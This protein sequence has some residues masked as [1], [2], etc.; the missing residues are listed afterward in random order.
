MLHRNR[1]Q[2]GRPDSNR[3]SPA[4]EAG[5][6]PGF[7][8]PRVVQ[9]PSGS[10]T[11]TSA[12][13]RRQAAATSWAHFTVTELSKNRREHRVGLEPTS[14]HYGCGVL[15]AGRP[16]HA[17]IRVGPE[18]LEPSPA[19]LRA[20]C[21]A[22]NT[23][24]PHRPL[25]VSRPGRSRTSV[26]RLSA[27]CSP[28]ELQAVVVPVPMG[29]EGFEPPPGGLKVRRAAVTPRPRRFGDRVA[30]FEP[31]H[32]SPPSPRTGSSQG[33]RIRTG[34]LQSPRLADCQAF[35]RPERTGSK[36]PVRESNPPPRLERAE[37]S[38]R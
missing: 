17:N 5:G 8:T 22:A 13:A 2:S 36:Q 9:V 18:G 3:R 12:M 20:G 15:A 34:A 21:A 29:P 1:C 19:R 25:R 30:M 6:L 37:S 26:A 7:P 16:V 27:G 31:D 4:P 38:I 33:G 23:W 24:V 10:R 35:P 32:R 11:R 28:V 14:P